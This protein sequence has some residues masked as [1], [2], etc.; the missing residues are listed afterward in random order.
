MSAFKKKAKRVVV[1]RPDGWEMLG[2]DLAP[3]HFAP[4]EPKPSRWMPHQGAREIARRA[5]RAK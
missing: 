5:A 3:I 4:V 1:Q 2:L